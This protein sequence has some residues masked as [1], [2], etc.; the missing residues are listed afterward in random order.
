MARLLFG[1]YFGCGNLGDDSILLGIVHGLESSGHDFTALSGTPEETYRQYG[2]ASIPRREQAAVRHAIERCDALVFPGGSIFQ[3][4]TSVASVHYYAQLVF[5]AK[6]AG[7]KIVMV[8]QGVGPLNKFLGKR[9]ALSAFTAADVIVVR[10]PSSATALAKLGVT[11]KV[12]IGA[13]SAFLLPDKV[14][15]D[16]GQGFMVGDM[17]TV[18]IAPRPFGRRTKEVAELFGGFARALFQANVMP[19]LIEMDRH[20]DGPLIDA[21]NKQQGGKIPDLRKIHTPMQM[22]Q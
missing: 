10:D 16:S 13:D 15:A 7:K 8:G 9:M 2:I 11:R 22:Q 6:K 19:V 20:E 4:V 21:I 14:A 18:G 12:R 3:D 17:R 5:L 1:G